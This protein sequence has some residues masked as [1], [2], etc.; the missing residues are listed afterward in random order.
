MAWPGGD[1]LSLEGAACPPLGR[2]A[3]T[4]SDH[5]I[6]GMGALPDVGHSALPGHELQ[7]QD[8]GSLFETG[9]ASADPDDSA[10]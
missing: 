8:T 6:S 10:G 9:Q 1:Q 7:G 3:S 4:G 5:R 2:A